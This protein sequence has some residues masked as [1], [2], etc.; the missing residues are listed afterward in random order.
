MH[1]RHRHARVIFDG[2]ELL[3]G[4]RQ[5]L[6]ARST[7]EVPYRVFD[8]VRI[9]G[10]MFFELL[11]TAQPVGARRA[12]ALGMVNRVVPDDELR[13]ETMKLAETLAAVSRPAMATTKQ[14]FHEVTD[15]PLAEGLTRG[16]NANKRM[17]AFVKK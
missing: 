10:F 16:R 6:G 5:A 2:N 4:G 8:V 7:E 11:A 1:L 9:D 12:L 14:L 3:S 13:T 17:R 15:L